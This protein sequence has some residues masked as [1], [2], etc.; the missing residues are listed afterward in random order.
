[1]H[2]FDSYNPVEENDSCT[3]DDCEGLYQCTLEEH[4]DVPKTTLRRKFVCSHCGH[5]QNSVFKSP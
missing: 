2:R 1:M 3:I 5:E 4:I